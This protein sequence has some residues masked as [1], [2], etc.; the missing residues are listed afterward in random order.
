MLERLIKLASGT[1]MATVASNMLRDPNVTKRAK[2][3]AASV[4]SQFI[5]KIK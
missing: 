3:L 2:S 1:K 5:K 4:L